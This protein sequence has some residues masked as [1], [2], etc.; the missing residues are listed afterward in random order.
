MTL[1]GFRSDWEPAP[2]SAPAGRMLLAIGDVHGHLDHLNA[3]I[4]HLRPE[5]RRARHFGL[6]V[7]LVLIGDYIDRGPNSLGVLRR[8]AELPRLL[9]VPVHALRGN[10]DQYLIDFL[11]TD[12]PEPASL[13]VWCGN[14]GETTLA[15]LGIGLSEVVHGD[16]RPLAARARVVA[17]RAVM[18]V[19]RGLELCRRIGDFLFVHAGV[20]PSKPLAEQGSHDL[21]W[22]RE[23]FLSATD[24]RHPF[25]VVHGHTIRGPEIHPHRIALDS[26]VYATGVLTAAQ[27]LDERLR[28]WC[29][30]DEPELTTFHRLLGTAQQHRFT[31]PAPLPDAAA[32]A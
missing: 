21:L 28:F 9:G 4:G 30:T 8:V 5:I 24:W 13:E 31:T 17:G 11:L 16:L 2:R 10:H 26:G 6:H 20:H 23:P 25:V 18:A 22:L 32:E 12:A 14:G 3:L 27:I 15:E 7:E 19:L 29:V 1:Y